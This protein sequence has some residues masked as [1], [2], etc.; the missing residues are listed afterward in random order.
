MKK[1]RHTQNLEQSNNLINAL[2]AFKDGK[3][4]KTKL[5]IVEQPG[6]FNGNRCTRCGGFIDEG[7]I[8]PCGYDHDSQTD[9]SGM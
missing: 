2:Q 4:D 9:H 1:I 6:C 8:C 5:K 3:S 7:G